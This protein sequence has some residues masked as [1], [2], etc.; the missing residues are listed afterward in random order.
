MSSRTSHA[1]LV[2]EHVGAFGGRLGPGQRAGGHA[3]LAL[4]AEA[5]QRADLAPEL[6]RLLGRQVAEVLDGELAVRVLVDD[7]RVDDPHGVRLPEPLELLDDLSVE[8]GVFE[9]QHHEL[10]RSDRHAIVLS[11]APR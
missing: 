10:N 6:D 4:D 11:P 2:G 3:V 9:A 1:V 7:E 5:D 8:V